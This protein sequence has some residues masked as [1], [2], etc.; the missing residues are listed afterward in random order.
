MRLT[1]ATTKKKA[2]IDQKSRI[3]YPEITFCKICSLLI[4]QE[5]YYYQVENEYNKLLQNNNYIVTKKD[6]LITDEHDAF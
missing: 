6:K 1:D 4:E 5:L 3:E 2:Q